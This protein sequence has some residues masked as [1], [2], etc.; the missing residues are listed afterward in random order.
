MLRKIEGAFNSL[1]ILYETNSEQFNIKATA[2]PI[3]FACT[4]EY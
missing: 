1:Y 4:A 3:I 2:I